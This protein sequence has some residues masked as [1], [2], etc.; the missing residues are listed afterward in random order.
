MAQ[1]QVPLPVRWI[2]L[3]YKVAAQ[4]NWRRCKVWEQSHA[5]ASAELASPDQFKQDK[6]KAYLNFVLFNDQFNVSRRE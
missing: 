2:G 1:F 6:P 3:V 5:V 4:A